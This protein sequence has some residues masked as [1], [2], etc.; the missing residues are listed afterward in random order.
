MFDDISNERSIFSENILF[1]TIR[2]IAWFWYKRKT[3]QA[4][5]SLGEL[6]ANFDPRI[7]DCPEMD[8]YAGN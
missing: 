3:W 6:H 7:S 8:E 2:R 4:A 1:Y 5:I